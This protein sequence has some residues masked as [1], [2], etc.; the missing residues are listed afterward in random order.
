M[1]NNYLLSQI[2]VDKIKMWIFGAQF[3][4]SDD[5]FMGV[6]TDGIHLKYNDLH[7]NID[8]F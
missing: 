7:Q 2:T 3:K 1:D 8:R 4:L 5:I 6:R